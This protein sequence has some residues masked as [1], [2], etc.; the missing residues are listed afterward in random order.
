MD[1]AKR[2]IGRALLLVAVLLAIAAAVITYYAQGYLPGVVAPRSFPQVDGELM[3]AGLDDTVDVYRDA[4]GIAHIYAS[5]SHD[6]FFAQGYVHAQERFWQ[7]D[8]WRHIGSGRLSEMF[9]K[10]TLETDAFLRTLGWREASERDLAG[11]SQESRLLL[12]AYAEGVNAYLKDR[13]PDATSLEYAVLGLLSPDYKIE[14]WEPLHSMTWAKAMAWDLRGNLNQE[15]ERAV[16]LKSLGPERVNELFPPYPADHPTIVSSA[17]AGNAG[18]AGEGAALA[19]LPDG[20]LESVQH[21]ASLLNGLLGPGGRGIGSNSWVLAGSRTTTGMPLFANDPHLSIQMPSIWYQVGMHCRPKTDLCPYSFAGFSF[22]GVPGIVIG[23]N[24]DIVWGM[25]N[26]EPD[27]MDLFIERVNPENPDQ[28]EVRGAWVDFEKRTEKIQVAGAEPVELVIKS[29]RHGPVISSVYGELKDQTDGKDKDFVPF[30]ERAGVALPDD[31]VISLAWT[32]LTQPSPFEAVWAIN[33]AKDWDEFRQAARHFAAPPQ[34]L[35][36]ADVRGNIGYQLPGDY[37]IRAS[38]DGRFPVPGWTGEYDWTGYIP[39][40]DQ[41]YAFN[42]QAGHI[43]AANNQVVPP[44]YP[45]LISMDWN[46]GF[47]AQRIVDM[48][49][50]APAKVDSTYLQTMQADTFDPVAPILVPLLVDA[51]AAQGGP[52]DTVSRDA[53][54]VLADWD[55]RA[56]V[57]SSGAAIFEAF[58]NHLL[59]N[60][61]NDDLP[62]E[63]AVEG[64][65]RWME[66]VRRIANDEASAWW[67][68]Q[69]TPDAVETRD[70]TM[71]RSFADAAKELRAQLGKDVSAWTWGRLHSA[72]FRNDTL[73]TSGIGLIESLFN[74][75]PFPTGGGESIVNATG[76]DVGKSYEVTWLPSLRM[77]VDLSNLDASLTV[78]TTG[79]SGHAYHPHYVDMAPLWATG[80]YYPMFW[81]EADVVKNSAEHLTLTP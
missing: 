70:Q 48:I 21:N 18:P 20:L 33:R 11:L 60:T 32:A 9:G 67:D 23:H 35:L 3:L 66:V 14:P 25:T 17:S 81:S 64:G 10:G 69:A 44:E 12:D 65:D 29:T 56:D 8:A 24:D 50:A 2:K 52:N 30:R 78:H 28:Y 49:E 72:T 4:W 76:W 6:L 13:D 80:K 26:V 59:Q 57:D 42:P 75:G 38:G 61:F 39:F 1:T 34:N 15:I 19:Y 40:E 31:Y 41:P 5:T 46:Y 36:F 45:Y 22:A 43:V 51:V 53:L 71:T 73:G 62:K 54:Q 27:V 74:R 7:M 77:V 58:W 55:Y 47:R 63:F 79:Q 68:D 37:P 16:L